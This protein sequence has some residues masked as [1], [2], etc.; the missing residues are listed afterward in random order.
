M[1]IVVVV[2]D[3]VIFNNGGLRNDIL[4][5]NITKRHI[6]QL[7]PFENKL[8]I[9]SLNHQEINKLFSY[10]N[11]TGGQPVSFS[12]HFKKLQSLIKSDSSK[13]FSRS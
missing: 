2:V 8:V 7:M 12:K 10:L 6:Y 3:M 13:R 1:L 5:G 9:L 11:E 4:K